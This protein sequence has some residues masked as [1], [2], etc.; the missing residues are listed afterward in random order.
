MSINDVFAKIAAIGTAIAPITINGDSYQVKAFDPPPAELITAN[1]PTQYAML[2][3]AVYDEEKYGDDDVEEQRDFRVC[4]AVI[5]EGLGTP[6]E[7]ETRCRPIL[8]AVRSA[9]Q[10][11]PSLNGATGV[12]RSRVMGD[13]GIV[14]LPDYDS[15]FI[16]FQLNL[17]VWL[18]NERTYATGE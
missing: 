13:S 3:P 16:G 5:P 11:R 12:Q 15:L 14:V 18:V 1:L 8:L 6:D 10:S 17:R 2:G 7:R 4:I 9:F